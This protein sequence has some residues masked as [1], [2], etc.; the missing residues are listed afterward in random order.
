MHSDREVWVLGCGT[1]L[2]NVHPA[3]QCRSLRFACPLHA[4]SDH[5]LAGAELVLYPPNRLGRTCPHRIVHPDIDDV[6]FRLRGRVTS[7][8]EPAPW[9]HTYCDGCCGLVF[10]PADAHLIPRPR[11]LNWSPWLIDHPGR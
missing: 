4:P 10:D 7:V 8:D 11:G 6:L 3:R 5:A 1:V 2:T 9:A